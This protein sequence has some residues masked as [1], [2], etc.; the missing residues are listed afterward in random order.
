MRVQGEAE[1]SWSVGYEGGMRGKAR[2]SFLSRARSLNSSPG[3]WEAKEGFGQVESRLRGWFSKTGSG[4]E[5]RARR[6]LTPTSP[7]CRWV[8]YEF[9]G[10]RGRQYVFERGEYR[11]WNEWDA[12]QPQLQSVRRI[13]DQKWHKRG[14]FLSS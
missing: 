4:W 5:A 3:H 14:V 12:N 7:P 6:L 11:H 9:P 13:R 1:T 2:V 10:Y 8:G